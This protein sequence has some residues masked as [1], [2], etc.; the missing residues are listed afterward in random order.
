MC[1]SIQLN[2]DNNCGDFLT[3]TTKLL[4]TIE[5]KK[6]LIFSSIGYNNRNKRNVLTTFTKATRL[7]FGLCNAECIE[8]FDSVINR[9]TGSSENQLKLLEE[10]IK[11]I[12]INLE[13]KELN[14]R[15]VD[16]DL[17]QLKNSSIEQYM[18]N[19]LLKHF[20]LSNLILA[21]HIFETNTLIEIIQMAKLGHIHPN[22][23]APQELLEQFRDIKISLPTGTELPIEL[24]LISAY[25]LL[26]L[27]D[28]TVYF[29]NNKIV[30]V[31]TLPL[32][33]QNDLTMYHLIPK[34]VCNDNINC[35]YIKPSYNFLAISKTKE[36]YT[37]Y[38]QFHN[39]A[40]K[41]TRNF[42]LCPEINPLHPRSTRPIC[43][44]QLLQDPKIVP[45]SCEIMHVKMATTIFQK[46]QFQN[47]WLY[48]TS[49]ETIFITCD[50]D[51]ES[52]SHSIKGVGL[53]RLNETCKGYA[54]RDVLIPGEVNRG[55]Y[56]DFIPTS[57]I[58]NKTSAFLAK[59]MEHKHVRNNK[60][61]DLND[62]SNSDEYLEILVNSTKHFDTVKQL[63]GTYDLEIYIIVSIG[64]FTLILIVLNFMSKLVNYRRPVREELC[65]EMGIQSTELQPATAPPIAEQPS[66]A[67]QYE[68]EAVEQSR[69]LYP[70]MKMPF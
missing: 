34:P 26:R 1:I 6:Q 44:V 63:I 20:S 52:S 45:D 60:M 14:F 64:S 19:Y 54:S 56:Q 66:I 61:S 8:K 32:V 48:A 33:Y 50:S 47:A 36:L 7:L 39:S 49:G 10:Q 30:F 43:E 62:I 57:R 55:I 67:E 27:S 16:M 51:K 68:D 5:T 38:D 70:K 3:Y 29:S 13:Q 2:A 46:L 22:L 24:D 25:E 15:K 9:L 35:M 53:L 69:P 23:L 28:L 12:K 11:I 21:K 17:T 40:C 31:I 58:P 37:T 4:E 59:V 41:H 65:V 42:L 18:T